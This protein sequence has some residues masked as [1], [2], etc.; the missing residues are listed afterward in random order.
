MTFSIPVATAKFSR[1]VGTL[2]EALSQHYLF[3]DFPDSSVCK[4][5]ACNSGHP[6][7]I[8]GLGRSAGEGIATHSSI[9]GLLWWLRW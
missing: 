4:E 5:F 9:L 2:S 3:R 1:F 6:G 7:S 8:P